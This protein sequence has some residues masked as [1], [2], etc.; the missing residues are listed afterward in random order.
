MMSTREGIESVQELV[1]SQESQPGTHR[2][3]REI[4]RE[5]DQDN[6]SHQVSVFRTQHFKPIFSSKNSTINNYVT[7]QNLLTKF[8]SLGYCQIIWQS[9]FLANFV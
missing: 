8:A 2:P 6:H 1:L 9:V 4:A 5:T 3:V 7:F